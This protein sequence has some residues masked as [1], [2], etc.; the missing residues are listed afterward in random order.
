MKSK[1][2][3]AIC[4]CLNS[5]D[6]MIDIG[7]DHAYVLIEMAKRGMKKLLGTEIHLAAYQNAQKNIIKSGYEKE[8]SL[9]LTDGTNKV[10]IYSYDTL[11]LA[12][13][14]YFTMKH[15]LTQTDLTP[16]QKIVLAPNQDEKKVRIFLQSIGYT[17]KKEI[18]IFEKKHF[19]SIMVYEKG[20]QTLT[21]EEKEF[22]LFQ[23]ENQ[24]YYQFLKEKEEEIMHN[25]PASKEKERK[26]H[27][28][29]ITMLCHY[30]E[31]C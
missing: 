28:K 14:G 31:K 24:V 19:Y 4:D 21:E 5:S 12:G 30:L 26:V 2:L 18:V 17:L 11:V 10:D 3:N 8:I 15:I 13:M 20:V 29:R 9:L 27:Q 1:R 23:K 22:G 7:C 16:I 25:I 6:K